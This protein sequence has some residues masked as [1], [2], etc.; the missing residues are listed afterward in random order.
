[1]TDKSGLPPGFVVFDSEKKSARTNIALGSDG[2]LSPE[3]KRALGQMLAVM[4]APLEALR[5]KQ[6][7]DKERLDAAASIQADAGASATPA[8]AA[9]GED[10]ERQP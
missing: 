2:E 6:N 3:S 5:L 9:R 7:A 4:L 8:E 1:M 10:E